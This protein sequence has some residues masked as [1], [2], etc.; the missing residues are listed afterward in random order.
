MRLGEAGA[1]MS[2]ASD[3]GSRCVS[4]GMAEIAFLSKPGGTLAPKEADYSC[5]PLPA[6]MAKQMTL[7]LE[8]CIGELQQ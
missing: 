3:W 2:C 6:V 5:W 4:S 7:S 1:H 8:L